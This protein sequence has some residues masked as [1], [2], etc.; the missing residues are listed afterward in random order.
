M[1]ASI[2][3]HAPYN[4]WASEKGFGCK[5][6]ERG[7]GLRCPDSH[8]VQALVNL[9]TSEVTL[10]SAYPFTVMAYSCRTRRKSLERME[11][12]KDHSHRRNNRN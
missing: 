2:V 9:P 3:V 1:G 6:G 10:V 4:R 11:V 5:R 8:A 12:E 7:S